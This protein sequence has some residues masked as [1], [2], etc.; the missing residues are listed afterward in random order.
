MD[1]DGHRDALRR[2]VDRPHLHDLGHGPDRLHHRRRRRD[3]RRRLQRRPVEEGRAP[4][5]EAR[6]GPSFHH[7][8]RP[9][10]ARPPG[11]RGA[12][13]E[14]EGPRIGHPRPVRRARRARPPRRPGFDHLHL[15]HDR[16]AEGRRPLPSQF[17]QQHPDGP[18]DHRV[19]GA[20]RLPVLPSPLPRPRAD[21]HV[22]VSLRRLHHRL[23]RERGGRRP[24]PAGGPADHH[25]Q[26][27]PGLREDLYQG[28]GP[29]PRQPGPA[30]EDLLLGPRGRPPLRRPEARR[31]ARPGRTA[32][33]A[34]RSP[35]SSSSP[36]SSPG[37][38][39][40][41]GSSS[42]AG[43]PCPRRSPSSSTPSAWSSSRGTG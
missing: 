16:G 6:Q 31:E 18:R 14:G 32:A 5:R 11:L 35:T 39:A 4:P 38:A 34:R 3:R 13:G 8:G 21:G 42:R 33:A 10:A 1:H 26:R 2:R 36:R 9:D 40:G 41:S 19:H 37:P 29:G 43:R 15:G 17:P 23:R 28:H 7:H 27:P 25:G 30:A 24:E 22:H 20:G 12:H